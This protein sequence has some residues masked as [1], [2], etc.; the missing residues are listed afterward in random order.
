MFKVTAT[1]VCS[2]EVVD[3]EFRQVLKLTAKR[4]LEWLLYFNLVAI[5]MG[6]VHRIAFTIHM[7]FFLQT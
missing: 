5:H 4:L 1:S 2:P 7:G 3:C 6:S